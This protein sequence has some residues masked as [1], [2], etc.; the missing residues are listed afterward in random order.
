MIYGNL[1]SVERDLSCVTLLEHV[2]IFWK[3][4]NKNDKSSA[5]DCSMETRSVCSHQNGL[6]VK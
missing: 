4:G 1:Y 5:I 2:L 6:I 3:M